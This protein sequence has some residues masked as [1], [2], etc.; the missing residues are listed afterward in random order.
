MPNW[1]K[2]TGKCNAF[3]CWHSRMNIRY[4]ARTKSRLIN[5]SGF[6]PVISVPGRKPRHARSAAM[7]SV[8]TSCVKDPRSP[9]PKIPADSLK[10]PSPIVA[11]A[12]TESSLRVFQ[13]G[14]GHRLPEMGERLSRPRP[15]AEL[16]R[17]PIQGQGLSRRLQ[18]LAERQRDPAANARRGS[19]ELYGRSGCV[20]AEA[21]AHLVRMACQALQL[22][23]RILFQTRVRIRSMFNGMASSANSFPIMSGLGYT[24]VSFL[25][26]GSIRLSACSLPLA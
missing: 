19:H 11:P 17:Q 20:S 24:L 15:G 6:T 3:I 14:A 23:V 2:W 25:M 21:L 22:P 8:R 5:S 16:L 18:L 10:A 1:R 26:A 9:G 13:C 4:R 12:S 7:P